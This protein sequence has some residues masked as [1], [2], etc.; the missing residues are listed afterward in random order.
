MCAAP[1]MGFPTGCTVCARLVSSGRGC[2]LPSHCSACVTRGGSLLGVA[3]RGPKW[4]KR[5]E[6]NLLW[7]IKYCSAEY[8]GLKVLFFFREINLGFSPHNY[9]Y[10]KQPVYFCRCWSSVHWTISCVWRIRMSEE[11]RN[12][13]GWIKHAF[14]YL[15]ISRNH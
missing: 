6:Y 15:S 9:G 12:E 3:P 8:A 2:P 1:L 4:I 5:N 7:I 13:T 14:I 10:L 11:K